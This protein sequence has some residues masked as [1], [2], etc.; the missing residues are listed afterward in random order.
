MRM[1]PS[2]VSM[3]QDVRLERAESRRKSCQNHYLPKTI[4]LNARIP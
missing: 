3:Y 1:A 2:F 4:L